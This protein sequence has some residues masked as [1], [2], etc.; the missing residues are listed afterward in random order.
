MLSARVHPGESNSSWVMK[1]T[2]RMK[3]THVHVYT[4]ASQ[5]MTLYIHMYNNMC[6]QVICIYMCNHL[7]PGVLQ[8]LMS[9]EAQSLRDEFIFKIIPMLNPDGVINGR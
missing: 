1:G 7:S 8:Y 5:F 9:P 4:Y 3:C 2:Y 6:I